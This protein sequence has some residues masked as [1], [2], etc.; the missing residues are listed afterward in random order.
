MKAVREALGETQKTMSSRLGLGE[1]TWQA[2]ERNIN[3]PGAETLEKVADL[4][5]SIDWILTGRGEMR[6]GSGAHVD[7]QSLNA[8]LE[9]VEDWLVKNRRTMTPARK[10]QVVSSIYSMAAEAAAEGKP[11]IEARQVAQILKLVG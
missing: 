7:E 10:A 11:P 8:A 5:F 6:G 1:T 4:G 2:Y 3:K 9:L